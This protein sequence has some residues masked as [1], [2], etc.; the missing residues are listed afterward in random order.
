MPRFRG[1]F[2]LFLLVA[3]G[4]SA[5]TPAGDAPSP[6]TGSPPA[7]RSGNIE[8][9]VVRVFATLRAPD[10]SKPWTKLTAREVTGS[11]VVIEGNRILTNAH[12]VAY[13][14][15]IQI[16]G[17]GPGDKIVAK[18]E[19]MAPGIDLAVL[20]LAE[21]AFFDTHPALQRSNT[22][23][24]LRDSVTVY[25]F[26]TG[27][28]GMS[29][30]QGIVSRVDY[31][32]YNY[33]TSGL[34]VQIDAAINPGNSGGPAIVGDKLIGVAFSVLANAQ[35]IGYVIPTAEVETFLADIADGHYDGKP[36]MY[37][38]FQP[39]ENP[40]LRA[41][42]RLDP[43]V[44]GIVV[45][46]PFAG[47]PDN[48][49]RK[50]DV[51]T[52]VGNTPVDD[53]GNV[54]LDPSTRVRFLYAA[55]KQAR[56][57]RVPLTVVRGGATVT[58]DMPLLQER[59][60]LIPY[61]QGDTPDYFICGPFV[62]SLATEDYL[63]LLTNP[64]N[65]AGPTLATQLAQVGSPLQA[66]RSDLPTFP[67]EELV[68]VSAPFFSHP[69]TR[70]YSSPA[71]RIVSSLNGT[72]VKNLRH[73]VELIRD[74][75]ETSLVFQFGG[76][77]YDDMVFN[78]QELLAATEQILTDNGIRSLGSPAILDVWNKKP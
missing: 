1:S 37:D 34:R 63:S 6:T 31:T 25:G 75:T 18:V 68:I 16:Q 64:A 67:G 23:P 56:N 11:G 61:L 54:A 5:Q 22:V 55:E 12:V 28:T 8:P 41:H 48:P 66:R 77:G 59:P 27:G 60:K 26:P 62:F 70:G 49:L 13:A 7:A 24:R 36:T 45:Q 35:N 53:Q 19:A 20:S 65:A 14:N 73:L 10:L 9:S 33:G 21:P 40:A 44:R 72:K 39:L 47:T 38:D 52:R 50:W 30:T 71:L 76:H 29:I 32:R 4:V 78:R 15:Q 69:M 2:A 51:V 43:G 58:V 46:E 74:S 17:T 42:L 3:V 57:G